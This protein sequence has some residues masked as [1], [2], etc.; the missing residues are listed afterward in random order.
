MTNTVSQYPSFN[1]PNDES[2]LRFMMNKPTEVSRMAEK[3][4]LDMYKKNINTTKASSTTPINKIAKINKYITNKVQILKSPQTKQELLGYTNLL[5]N[6][7]N[8]DI[9]SIIKNARYS[10]RL[11]SA[12]QNKFSRGLGSGVFKITKNARQGVLNAKTN[13]ELEKIIKNKTSYNRGQREL[14]NKILIKRQWNTIKNNPFDTRK[15]PILSTFYY[16]KN[17]FRNP[18]VYKQAG[19]TLKE[20]KNVIRNPTF[21]SN[22]GITRQNYNLARRMKQ[23]R[24]GVIGGFQEGR[25]EHA[26]SRTGNTIKRGFLGFFGGKPKNNSYRKNTLPIMNSSQQPR[27]ENNLSRDQKQIENARREAMSNYN[28]KINEV[29]TTASV[30]ELGNKI[31]KIRN[32]LSPENKK[33]LLKKLQKKIQ[34]LGTSSAPSKTS[35]FFGKLFK[36]GIRAA[37][38]AANVATKMA[39]TR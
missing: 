19:K 13:D 17:A 31:M 22:K 12:A 5:E 25:V 15:I 7:S 21:N 33:Q 20:L 4:L 36:H 28:K 29:T 11:R 14:A 3:K 30:A 35:S 23:G 37:G 39:L 24:P 38:T 34:N 9:L 18:D 32:T 2:Q 16:G 26:I 27:M 10:Q 6:V 8:I 1:I